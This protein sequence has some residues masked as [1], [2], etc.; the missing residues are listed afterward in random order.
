MT[1]GHQSPPPSA[2]KRARKREL[3]GRPLPLGDGVVA[4]VLEIDEPEQLRL[5]SLLAGYDGLGSLHGDGNRVVVVTTE[6]Q[7]DALDE[8]LASIAR[9]GVRF[10]VVTARP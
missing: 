7:A 2:S 3:G 9:S 6:S 8:A 1:D 5:A 10:R 4:R